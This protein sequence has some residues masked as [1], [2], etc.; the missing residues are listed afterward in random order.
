MWRKN[1][2]PRTHKP[3]RHR[4]KLSRSFLL[5]VVSRP[6]LGLGERGGEEDPG[7]LGRGGRQ[8]VV[9]CPRD[10]AYVP[11]EGEDVGVDLQRGRDGRPEGPLVAA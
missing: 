4:F 10:A 7:V 6:L 11:G 2:I 1:K 9:A 3:F 8:P 5:T